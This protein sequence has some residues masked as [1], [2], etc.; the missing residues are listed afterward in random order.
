MKIR[1]FRTVFVISML[2]AVV[3]F[4]FIGIP[5]AGEVRKCLDVMFDGVQVITR[6]KASSL[7]TREICE[8]QVGLYDGYVA[9]SDVIRVNNRLE[10][11]GVLWKAIEYVAAFNHPLSKTP[12]Q[13]VAQHNEFCDEFPKLKIPPEQL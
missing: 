7:D 2:C 10:A 6:Y 11:S 5:A 12:S 9:C 13:F 3:L 4:F 1:I 8:R